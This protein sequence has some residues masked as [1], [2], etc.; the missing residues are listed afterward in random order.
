MEIEQFVFVCTEINQT[1]WKC[2]EIMNIQITM[3]ITE[4]KK[5][6]T[7]PFERNENSSTLRGERTPP[8]TLIPCMM[9]Q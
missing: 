6:C 4:R 7:T 2:S 5:K 1:P 9:S 8:Q 3:K